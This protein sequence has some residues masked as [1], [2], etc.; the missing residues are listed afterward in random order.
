MDLSSLAEAENTAKTQSEVLS[1]G[2]FVTHT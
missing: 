2:T 1:A